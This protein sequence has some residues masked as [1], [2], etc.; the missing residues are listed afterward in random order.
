MTKPTSRTAQIG[1]ALPRIC[2]LVLGVLGLASGHMF[3]EIAGLVVVGATVA[4]NWKA[5]WTY[6]VTGQRPST[7]T[8]PPA[9]FAEPGT[10]RVRLEAA[11]ERPIQVIKA[12]REVSGA[13]LYEAKIL[14]EGVPSIMA[15]QVSVT[16]ADR[17][18]ARLEAAG[19]TV[20]MEDVPAAG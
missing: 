18:R 3:A 13:D 12:I 11:G 20:S 14:V 8:P 7:A 9:E 15:D 2:V 6:V 5:W 4:T 17:V 19:A 16:S 10:Y 1:R